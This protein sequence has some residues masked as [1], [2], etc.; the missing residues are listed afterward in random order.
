MTDNSNQTINKDELHNLLWDTRRSVRYHNRRR[1]F[2]DRASNFSDAFTAI[3]GS[4]TVVTAVSQLPGWV[5]ITMA[6]ITAI[7]SSINLV[8]DTKG[9]ART[10]HDLSRNF[11][12]IE[13][14]L[15]SP[16]LTREIF[17]E[18]QVRRLEIEAEEP[19]VLRVLDLVCHN[20]L[21]KAMGYNESEYFKINLFQR[22]V[23]NFFDLFPSTV[24]K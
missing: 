14:A 3:A 7:L 8:F 10:H 22:I 6:A 1:L 19:P 24:K 15:I 12:E 23:A 11:I 20:E 5:P 18:S 4:G 2:Y 21:L 16:V 9:N 13:K 17:H